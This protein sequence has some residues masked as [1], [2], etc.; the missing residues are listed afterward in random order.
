MAGRRHESARR[1]FGFTLMEL[2]VVMSVII[3][4]AGVLLPA[5]HAIWAQRKVATA[6]NVVRG[7]LMT[8][9]P[10]AMEAGGRESGLLFMVDKD[11]T[12][13]VFPIAQVPAADPMLEKLPAER[14]RL[15]QNQFQVLDDREYSLPAPMRVVPRYAVDIDTTSSDDDIYTFSPAELASNSFPTNGAPGA[16]EAQRHRNYFTMV[17]SNEGNLRTW[18]DVLI[19]DID[20]DLDGKGDRTGLT[21]ASAARYHRQ[22]GDDV[23]L[24]EDHPDW[25]LDN[26]IVDEQGVAVNFPSVD[27]LLV[28][29]DSLFNQLVTAVG[30][31]DYLLRE[32]Q[33]FYVA[34]QSGAVVRGPLGENESS[35]E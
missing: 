33:P 1:A 26:L 20:E 31:R 5:V 19:R 13:R 17:Y 35:T 12:Q 14:E 21:V 25:T 24:V 8:T 3:I 11:G 18:R 29:D 16:S 10:R 9:R 6:E 15:G 22:D 27:G 7:L 28:Y 4:L 32:A 2:L 23:A 30:Q 34:R